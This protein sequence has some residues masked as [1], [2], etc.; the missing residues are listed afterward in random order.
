MHRSIAKR[1]GC[2][3]S[4]RSEPIIATTDISS[5]SMNIT[6]TGVGLSSFTASKIASNS[7]TSTKNTITTHSKG[8]YWAQNAIVDTINS[9]MTAIS[10]GELP[11]QSQ[12][13]KPIFGPRPVGILSNLHKLVGMWLWRLMEGR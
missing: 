1:K 8:T 13:I 11:L 9:C 10:T 5:S 12:A 2:A 3:R 4:R 7:T 6:I